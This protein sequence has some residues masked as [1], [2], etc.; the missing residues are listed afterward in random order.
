[1]KRSQ[2]TFFFATKLVIICPTI[3]TLFHFLFNASIM[4]VAT[5]VYERFSRL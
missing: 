1:M 3:S 2:A 4:I 5:A